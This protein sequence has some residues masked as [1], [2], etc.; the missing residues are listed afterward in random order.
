MARLTGSAV[1][2]VPHMELPH[3]ACY[4][5]LAARGAR[6]DGRVPEEAR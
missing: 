4:R 6:G 2:E 3:D 1:P 5:A